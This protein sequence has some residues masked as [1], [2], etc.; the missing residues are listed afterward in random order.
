[1]NVA[2]KIARSDAS[3][4]EHSVMA[5]DRNTDELVG[6]WPVPRCL[7]SLALKIARVPAEDALGAV[8]YRLNDRQVSGLGYLVGVEAPAE[9]R[10]FFLEATHGLAPG[11][12]ALKVEAFDVLARAMTGF[13]SVRRS[14][15]RVTPGE[16]IV[17]LLLVLDDFAS[18]WVGCRELAQR[19]EALL[20]L[21][22]SVGMEPAILSA[23]ELLRGPLVRPVL[24]EADEAGD[25]LRISQDGRR[26]IRAI[27]A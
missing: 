6:E 15:G 4:V 3:T 10:E 21:P 17:P 13:K 19:I 23:A 24:V 16:L 25:R 2:L 1:M 18:R 8:S 14:R 7:D 5:Y 9:A 22:D 20:G 11:F 27:R 12:P 26:V